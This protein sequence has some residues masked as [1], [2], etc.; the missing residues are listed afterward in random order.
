MSSPSEASSDAE[1][2]DIYEKISLKNVYQV[3][4]LKDL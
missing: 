2:H 1:E 4:I 3:N